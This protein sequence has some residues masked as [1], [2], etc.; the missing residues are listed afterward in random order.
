MEEALS[1]AGLLLGGQQPMEGRSGDGT[2]L[3]RWSRTHGEDG[4]EEEKMMKGG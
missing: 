3:R 1:L 4:E 2:R